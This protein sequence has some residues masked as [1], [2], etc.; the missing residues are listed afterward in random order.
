MIHSSGYV[1]MKITEKQWNLINEMTLRIH[2]TDD[3]DE[4]R[5]DFL[6]VL[7][8]LVPFDKASF[9]LAID[10]DPY[11]RPLG[12]GLSDYDLKQYVEKY[13][14]IDPFAPLI[15][16]F[17]D[18][19]SAIRV[20]DYIVADN[21]EKTEYYKLAWQPKN[22]LYSVFGP[23]S[24]DKNWLGSFSLFRHADKKDFSDIELDIINIL[25]AHMR[26]RLW[27]EKQFQAKL[28]AFAS[29]SGTRKTIY[30]GPLAAEHDL[31]SRECDVIE[32]WTSG[33][34]D[35]EICDSLSISKNTLK[36]HISNIFGKLEISSR[37]ELLKLVSK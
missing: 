31:T 7:K 35:T 13:A 3:L 36:K 21:L 37:V 25:T 6:S 28:D 30:G 4:M 26:T 23:L 27:R 20:S 22:I 34:T 16:I 1:I 29:V 24:V 9:Y 32:L 17:M 2:V 8:T 12:I 10:D 15:G 19:R 5:S 11:S 33:L 18:V 14:P